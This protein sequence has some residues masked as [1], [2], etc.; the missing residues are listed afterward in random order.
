MTDSCQRVHRQTVRLTSAAGLLAGAAIGCA[1][2]T[3]VAF[4]DEGPT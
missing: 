3:T 4:A 2:S 1:R